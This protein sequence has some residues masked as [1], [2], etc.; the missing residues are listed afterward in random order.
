MPRSSNRHVFFTDSSSRNVS[1]HGSFTVIYTNIQTYT[2]I[3]FTTT[4][5]TITLTIIY[6]C[7]VRTALLV[8]RQFRYGQV[9]FD[10]HPQWI[11]ECTS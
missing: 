5:T 9:D 1:S 11:Y 10:I 8:Q 4:T 3:N 7:F 2:I 6:D